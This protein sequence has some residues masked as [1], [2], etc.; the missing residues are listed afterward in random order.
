MAEDSDLGSE[1][2][3]FE[4]PAPDLKCLPNKDLPMIHR[5]KPLVSEDMQCLRLIVKFGSGYDIFP[6]ISDDGLSYAVKQDDEAEIK[7]V[8]PSNSSLKEPCMHTGFGS[9]DH[10]DT[11]ESNSNANA[12]S[13]KNMIASL[14]RVEEKIGRIV[15]DLKG[16]RRDLDNLSVREI[17]SRLD[18]IISQLG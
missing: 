10:D 14:E 1:S 13:F 6:D 7:E 4:S 8:S 9:F 11:N 15:T 18:D 5:D 16:I 12:G 17:R 2:S 3:G